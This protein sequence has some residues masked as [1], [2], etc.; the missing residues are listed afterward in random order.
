MRPAVALVALVLAVSGA[1]CGSRRLCAVFPCPASEPCELGDDVVGG[2]VE[3]GARDLVVPVRKKAW[4]AAFGGEKAARP[5]P[6]APRRLADD[7]ARRPDA[8]PASDEAF[9]EA[10]ARYVAR[11]RGV[12]RPRALLPV[13]NVRLGPGEPRVGDY[14]NVTTIGLRLIAIVAAYELELVPRPDAVA[15]VKGSSTCS[16][17]SRPTPGSSSTT[18]TRRRSSGRATSSRSSTPRG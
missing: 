14:T 5:R 4:E 8:L 11:A 10:R 2:R 18:T 17:G 16:M 12:H 13:D 3:P 7:A 6:R 15:R 1:G 9:V